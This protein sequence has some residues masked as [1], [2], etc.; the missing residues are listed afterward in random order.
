MK[1]DTYKN[2]FNFILYT[3]FKR[4]INLYYKF[5]IYHIFFLLQGQIFRRATKKLLWTVILE[6]GIIKMVYSTYCTGGGMLRAGGNGFG[7]HETSRKGSSHRFPSH[8]RYLFFFFVLNPVKFYANHFISLLV[9]FF[10]N[11]IAE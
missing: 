5:N 2:N 7:C 11:K 3:F 1:N 8:D 6:A 4:K 10:F 9:R